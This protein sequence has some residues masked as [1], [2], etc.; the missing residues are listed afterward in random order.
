MVIFCVLA[1]FA[2]TTGIGIYMMRQ[3]STLA[4]YFVA[5]KDL[6]P[7]L[8]IP[9]LFAEIIA[10]AGTVGNA[11]QAFKLGMSAVWVNW[12]MSI[13]CLVV[14]L[15]AAKFYR[16]IGNKVN[17]VSVPQIYNARFDA[18]T[19]MVMMVV[20][21]LVYAILF[22]MQ[23]VAAGNIL[24]P[25]LGVD[26]TMITWFLGCLFIVLCITGGMK[27]MAWMNALHTIV[28][29][30][31]L[32]T[33][34]FFAVK[35]AGGLENMQAA[36]PGTFFQFDQPD[37]L[38][39]AGWVLGTVLSFFAASVLIAG[40]F[41]ATNERAYKYG[42]SFAALLTFIFALFPAIIGVVGAVMLPEAE[43]GSILYTVANSLGPVFAVL[44][45]MGI[46]AAILSTGPA[47]LLLTST[48]LSEDVYQVF[49][50]GASDEERLRFSR[51][52]MA[53]L[54]IAATYFGMHAGSI[55]GQMAGAFQ[56]RAIAG[57]VLLVAIFWPRVD[58]RAAFWSILVGGLVAAVWHFAGNPYCTS[59]WPSLAVG[60][61]ILLILTFMAPKPISDGYALYQEAIKEQEAQGGIA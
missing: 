5:K 10:G 9:L 57:L 42:F 48:M 25:L 4:G 12:G 41:G 13:G 26:K 37:L 38:T 18:K 16:V 22:A 61:P 6:G 47:L 52:S 53:V 51:I 36:L 17:A 31:G 29:Y 56:I 27:G 30:V 8:I 33:V 14:M 55:L 44:A 59:L 58:S 40:I 32:G 1:Y 39:M 49:K 54:G 45:S 20:L 60:V 28:M 23:P 15:T 46:L 24:S 34:A 19:R 3:K 11:A 2:I 21:V 50:K 35:W 7:M 43:G